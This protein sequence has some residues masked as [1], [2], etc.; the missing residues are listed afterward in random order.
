MYPQAVVVPVEMPATTY[1]ARVA[2]T[3]PPRR[4]F[5][6]SPEPLLH[7]LDDKWSFAT[8]L[9]RLGV[10]QPQTRLVTSP[11]EVDTTDVSFPAVV[12]PPGSEG[13]RGMRWV[14][15][16]DELRGAVRQ[17]DAA[18]LLPVLVQQHI[19]G[20]HVA[21]SGLAEHGRIRASLVHRPL[22]GGDLDI[23]H[24]PDA[25]EIARTVVAA[26]EFHGVFNIDFH[27]EDATGTLYTLEINPRLKFEDDQRGRKRLAELVLPPLRPAKIA[28]PLD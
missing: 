20:Q 12:K 8:I 10:P 23:V 28:S 25:D 11:A 15:S 24:A 4:A 21:V 2:P 18:G 22:A 1:L 14:H 17:V 27:R 3:L 7:E 13:S 9:E 5:P 19:D 16:V 6:L 26:T